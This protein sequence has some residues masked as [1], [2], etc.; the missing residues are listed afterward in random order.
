MNQEKGAQRLIWVLAIVLA[1]VAVFTWPS[2]KNLNETKQQITDTSHTIQKTKSSME[3]AS[4]YHNSFDLTDAEKK[5][6]DQITSAVATVW[7]GIKS[8]DDYQA[9]KTEINRTLGSKMVDRMLVYI[10][11]QDEN[12]R[13]RIFSID[14]NDTTAVT[15][16]NVND[17][18]NATIKVIT[19][20]K[21]GGKQHT[22]LLTIHWNLKKQQ[23]IS[24][25]L[26]E[27][28]S[29]TDASD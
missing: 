9:K 1:V 6:S 12:P 20:P 28:D 23:L 4:P 17:V 29:S 2:R 3:K 24:D 18:N 25:S 5:A 8:E 27:L 14:G 13:N 22:F 10:T 11:A 7:G 19:T 26:K 21:V 15:F 16:D